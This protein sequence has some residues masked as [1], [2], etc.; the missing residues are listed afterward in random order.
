MIATL[1]ISIL[2]CVLLIL[3]ILFFPKVKVFNKELSTYWIICLIGS[4]LI[5]CL[6]LVS[7]D[8]V[9]SEFFSSSSINPLKILI[10]FFSMTFLSIFL[11]EVGFFRFLA[12]FLIL[13][14]KTNQK[15]LFLLMYV[16]VAILTIFIQDSY[17]ASGNYIVFAFMLAG[18]IMFNHR[19]NIV[20]I[21]KGE[22]NRI[23]FKKK[24]N[25]EETK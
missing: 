23:S 13:K 18:F 25:V 5:L 7:F 22:E 12:S 24:E 11:D 1:I 19:T 2:T 16:M 4:L 8:S 15:S 14:C 21:F 17:I 3:S 10:L 6:N 9:I 20:R